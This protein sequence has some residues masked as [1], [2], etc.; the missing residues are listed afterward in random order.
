MPSRG[1]RGAAAT[2][3]CWPSGTPESGKRSGSAVGAAAE[4]LQSMGDL[5]EAVLD[6]DLVRPALDRRS[7][8]LDRR[9]T[10]PADQ[11]VVVVGAAALPEQLLPSLGAGGVNLT[12]VDEQLQGAVDGREPYL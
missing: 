4:D 8:H 12:G 7:A 5:G 3:R 1:W 11:M 10:V 2:T 6:G 9:P